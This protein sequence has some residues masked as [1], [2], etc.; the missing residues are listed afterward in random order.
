MFYPSAQSIGSSVYF[1]FPLFT[2][3]IKPREAAC[4]DRQYTRLD[5]A[6]ALIDGI[7][8]SIGNEEDKRGAYVHLYGVGLLASLLALK[9]GFD[10]QTAEMAEIAGMLHDLLT[11]VDRSAD[12]DDHAH[13]CADYAKAH[14]LDHLT[15]FSEEEKA[16]MY[17]GIYNHS[18]K[19]VLGDPFDELIKDADAAQHALRNPMED[20]FYDKPRIQRA[21]Q[22]L[23]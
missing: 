23:L 9:R 2:F 4:V 21:I 7:I 8:K 5:E 22:E 12:T 10:R 11:Y 14:V 16:M 15:C 18:D 1:H 6:R 17:R 3:I 13:T 20:F 19:R